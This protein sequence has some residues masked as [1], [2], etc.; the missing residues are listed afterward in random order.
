M[1]HVS[2]SSRDFGLKFDTN[3]SPEENL[4]YEFI[5]FRSPKRPTIML[6]SKNRKQKHD[7]RHL[8]AALASMPKPTHPKKGGGNFSK[9]AP[10]PASS[11]D[12][13]TDSP[14][15]ESLIAQKLA[16]NDPVMRNRAVKK[17]K[18]WLEARSNVEDSVPFSEVSLIDGGCCGSSG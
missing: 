6:Q 10:A 7:V 15:V 9:P 3:F 17:L 5:Q 16:S 12:D 8:K 1:L 2:A 4:K 14:P 18:K 13:E 11:G